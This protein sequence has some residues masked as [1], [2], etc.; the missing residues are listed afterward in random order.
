MALPRPV[1][2]AP[3]WEAGVL[4]GLGVPLYLVTMASQNLP[5]FATLRAAGYVPPVR[6]ALLATGGL[7]ML[8]ALFG[9]HPVNMAAITAAICLGDDVHPD[10][11]Q[12]CKVSLAYGGVWVA[13]GLLS[14]L[15]IALVASLPAPLVSAIV[16]L[17]L[18]GSLSGALGTA[19]M[20]G[21]Q[22]FAAAVTLTTTASGVSFLGIGAAFWG[23]LAGLA[24]S[25]LGRLRARTGE[26]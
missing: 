16:A 13:L 18:F 4:V 8:A 1:L 10:P 5:G 25:G 9:G 24:V 17:A 26:R 21:P 23:L 2:I 20:P 12:R 7:S 3:V 19:F 14:P 22:R 11:A 15:A 6:P